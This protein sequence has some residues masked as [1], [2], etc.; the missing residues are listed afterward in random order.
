[1]IRYGHIA[2]R[3]LGFADDQIYTTLEMKM[4]CGVGVCGRCNLDHRYICKDGP[5]FRMDEF[6]S[7]E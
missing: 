6:K 4:K 3:D 2:L 5:V 7:L 1:M